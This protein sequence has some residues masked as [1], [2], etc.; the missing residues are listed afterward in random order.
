MGS[1]GLFF[2]NELLIDMND[3][4]SEDELIAK[5]SVHP[6]R[7]IYVN[8]SGGWTLPLT[9]TIKKRMMKMV[10]FLIDNGA[11]INQKDLFN[12]PL[13]ASVTCNRPLLKYLLDKGADVTAYDWLVMEPILDTG[14]VRTATLLVNFNNSH[15]EPMI[16]KSL[17]YNSF[18]RSRI[19]RFLHIEQIRIATMIFDLP[20]YIILWITDWLLGSA[21]LNEFEKVTFIERVQASVRK[22]KNVEIMS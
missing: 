3:N 4:K 19:I 22:V 5:W 7:S 17:R 8:E 10:K 12:T 11:D 16:N 2:R 14:D 1:W 21:F 13:S 20:Q 15:I 9:Y 6:L 18:N